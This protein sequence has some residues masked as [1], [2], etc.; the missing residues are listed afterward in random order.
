MKK[1]LLAAFITLPFLHPVTGQAQTG[2]WEDID[3]SKIVKRDTFTQ[4]GYTLVWINMS[5]DFNEATGK[6][7]VETFFKVYPQEAAL[8]N[9]KTLRKVIMIIDPAYK[10]VAATDA[11]VI[12]VSPDWMKQ[13]PEDIDVV[14]HE[15]MHIVQAYPND[16]GPG[17]VTEGIAD[18]VRYTLGVNNDAARWALPELKSTQNYDNAYRI[19]ARFLV[20]IE[21]H[22]ARGFVQKLDAVMRKK[23]YTDQFWKQQAGADVADL[24]KE[25]A[26]N[27]SI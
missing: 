22:K 24:W 14:T 2:R 1:I 21:K 27:P 10:G 4:K 8:Y 18:Y 13:H 5:P 9:K 26:A 15:A 17:W 25:Y 19:T 12:R 16:S 23:T 3:N 7:M 6:R 20:W 11:G